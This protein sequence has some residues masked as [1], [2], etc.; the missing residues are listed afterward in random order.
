Y[1][2]MISASNGLCTYEETVS[3]AAC[4]FTTVDIEFTNATSAI[5]TD[6]SIVIT[7]VSGVSPFQYSIDGGQNFSFINSFEGL[8]IGDYNIVVLDDLGVCEYEIGVPIE[9][10]GGVNIENENPLAELINLYPNPT[11]DQINIEIQTSNTL[12]EAINIV[13]FDQLGRPIDTSVIKQGNTRAIISLN[14]YSSGTYFVKCYTETF[15]RNF[16][17]IKI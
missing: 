1:D 9:A 7:P 17:V 14:G 5:T 13:V 10:L 6:G 11:S 12:N 16:K 3:I 2:V 15:E 4:E 8:P